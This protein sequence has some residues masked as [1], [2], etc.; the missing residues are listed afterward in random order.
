MGTLTLLS[1]RD[2]ADRLRITPRKV[3]RLVE[4]DR[5][6]AAAKAPGPRG[7]FMFTADELDRYMRDREHEHVDADEPAVDDDEVAA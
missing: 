6:R 4:A 7:A 2:V 1:T 5:L 3:S